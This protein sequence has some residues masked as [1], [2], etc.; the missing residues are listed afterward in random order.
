MAGP[1]ATALYMFHSN[2][3][4]VATV[5]KQEKRHGVPC[6]QDGTSGRKAPLG[7]TDVSSRRTT[8]GVTRSL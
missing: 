8:R 3:D 6:M 2:V 4:Y 5:V 7:K 1:V